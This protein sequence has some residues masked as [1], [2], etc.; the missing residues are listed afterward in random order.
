MV[1]NCK[2]RPQTTAT[3][4]LNKIKEKQFYFWKWVT[5]L[6]HAAKQDYTNHQW[7]LL[8][9]GLV[10][11]TKDYDLTEEYARLACESIGVEFELINYSQTLDFDELSKINPLAPKIFFVEED[12]WYLASCEDDEALNKQ[13]NLARYIS[14]L[15]E[16]PIIFIITVE[17]Y[18][19]VSI[20]F[21][22]QGL[23]DRHIK[24]LKPQPKLMAEDLIESLGTELFEESVLNSMHRL[25]CLLCEE[26]SISRKY[27]LLKSALKRVNYFENRKISWGDLFR[28]V[29]NGTG[30][31]HEIPKYIDYNKI[32]VH[33]A[34]HALV[35]IVE[36]RGENIP[37]VTTILPGDGY[38][39]VVIDDFA[40]MH[41]TDGCLSFE[42][43]CIKIRI[44]LAG[45]AAEELIFGSMGVDV[46]WARDDLKQATR[47]ALDLVAKGGFDH[48]Y[49]E[50]SGGG[51]NLLICSN[52]AYQENDF[53][54]NEARILLANQY[55]IIRSCLVKNK[56][57]LDKIVAALLEKKFLD[58]DDMKKIMD[59]TDDSQLI[60]A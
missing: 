42:E 38:V 1:I 37:D 12:D 56:L 17:S 50:L 54:K 14:S 48:K 7:E 18:E 29:S 51:I 21:R 41:Q 60:A 40:Y 33:E 2:S 11:E 36:S 4:E 27:G 58:R 47:I 6:S 49:G 34:G 13:S 31:G 55:E 9:H 24:W 45:R 32:A 35:A 57:F 26:F 25:G 30:E 43:A 28:I 5:Q 59:W 8:G 3:E 15:K 22:R 46:F 52:N 16:E 44:A 10:I 39:G 53:Y 19:E 23:F 20:K